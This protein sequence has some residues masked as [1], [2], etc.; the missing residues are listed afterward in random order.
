[1][2]LKIISLGAAML[3]S[4]VA[5]AQNPCLAAFSFKGTAEAKIAKIPG[6][7]QL[8]EQQDAIIKEYIVCATALLEAEKDYYL[9]LG[10][11][12]EGADLIKVIG[13]IKKSS[14]IADV[15]KIAKIARDNLKNIKLNLANISDSTN[16]DAALWGKSIVQFNEALR[17]KGAIAPKCGE[18]TLSLMKVL[19]G[20]GKINKT[21]LIT[22]FNN[23]IYCA[24]SLGIEYKTNVDIMN[25]M[26]NVSER[27]DLEY[28]QIKPYKLIDIDALIDAGISKL[29]GS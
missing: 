12:T 26:K 9:A 2:K 6:V 4:P 18:T 19:E 22:K 8:T 1:M 25:E 14:D 20:Q 7:T 24:G 11:T 13:E 17:V 15:K 10:M 29:L 28:P 5:T 23:I 16:I 27:L 21:I 3:M